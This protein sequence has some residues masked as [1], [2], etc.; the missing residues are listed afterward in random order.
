MMQNF[1]RDT[2][3]TVGSRVM[4]YQAPLLSDFNVRFFPKTRTELRELF[5]E[6]SRSIRDEQK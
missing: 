1:D 5:I 2:V 6:A 3:R 4:R